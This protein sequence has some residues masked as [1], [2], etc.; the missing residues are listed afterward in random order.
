VPLK[1]SNLKKKKTAYITLIHPYCVKTKA[2][3]KKKTLER[4][5]NNIKFSHLPDLDKNSTS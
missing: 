3:L 1:K 2:K 5:Y 4:S